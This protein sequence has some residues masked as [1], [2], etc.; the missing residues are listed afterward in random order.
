MSEPNG[1]RKRRAHSR[2]N[3]APPPAPRPVIHSHALE[4]LAPA[5]RP[6]AISL[7]AKL[8][9]DVRAV[10]ILGPSGFE[11]AGPGG[12]AIPPAVLKGLHA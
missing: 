2:Q 12:T 5:L 7:A 6:T 1:K 11:I 9:L 3:V 4:D 8:G 10:D